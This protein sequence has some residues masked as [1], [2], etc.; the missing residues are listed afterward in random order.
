MNIAILGATGN[1]GSVILNE[2]L[3][4]GHCVTAIARSAARLPDQAQVV[5]RS[6][7]ITDE[8]AL[9]ATLVEHDAVISALKFT[10]LD[11]PSLLRA[12]RESRVKRLLVVGGA[13]SLEMQPGLALVDA[14]QFPAEYK[15][16]ALGGRDFLRAL[17]NETEIDWTF[18]SPSAF[19]FPGP[20]TGKFRLGRDQLLI[21]AEGN[22]SVSIGDFAVAMLNELEQPQHARQRFTVGY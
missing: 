11:V 10:G 6:L 3:Q 16:E 17:Q 4:R 14:P 5:R 7:D 12:V 22:S 15:T 2:A 20:A 18:L 8:A 9:S 19:L 21:D 1:V 13:G